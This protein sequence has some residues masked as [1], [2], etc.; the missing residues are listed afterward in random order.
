M[1]SVVKRSGQRHRHIFVVN[2]YATVLGM[3]EMGE[4]RGLGIIWRFRNQNTSKYTKKSFL[5][6]HIP[7]NPG[8]LCK[9]IIGFLICSKG[10]SWA[11]IMFQNSCRPFLSFSRNFINEEG[12]LLYK[13]RRSFFLLCFS[14][15]EWFHGLFYPSD[16]LKIPVFQYILSCSSL[17]FSISAS[18]V[19]NICCK[20][21][22]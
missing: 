15:C 4:E 20:N 5:S 17:L 3:G 13:L 18:L 7:C 9:H 6:L 21:M 19:D 1:K 12:R 14:R 16:A 22:L 8:L 10:Y 11:I 2:T